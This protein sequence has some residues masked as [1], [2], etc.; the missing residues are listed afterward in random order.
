MDRQQ[1]GRDVVTDAIDADRYR[2]L[3]AICLLTGEV[4]IGGIASE[5]EFDHAV[6]NTMTVVRAAALVPVSTI[7]VL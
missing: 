2:R 4:R 7:M 6:D 1:V 3:R 5:E